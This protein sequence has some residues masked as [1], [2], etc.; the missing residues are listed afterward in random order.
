M[1]EAQ[2]CSASVSPQVPAEDVRLVSVVVPSHNRRHCL[3]YCLEALARQTYPNYEV[4][5]VDDGSDDGTADLLAEFGSQHPDLNLRW[6]VNESNIG[7][8]KSRNRGIQN[9]RGQLV[10]FLDSDCIAEP[11]W[12]ENLRRAFT[13]RQVAAVTGMVLNAPPSNIY[14][15]TYSGTNRVHGRRYPSRLT[16]CNMCVR[17]DLLVQ[18]PFDED[19]KYGC[20]E[21]GIYLRFRAIG[22]EQ[23]VVPDAVLRHEH[24][25]TRQTFFRQ[26][27]LGGAAAAWLV[28]KYR[29]LPRLDLLPF[30]LGY[31]TLPLGLVNAWLLAI[32]LLFLGVALVA[33]LYNELR[34]KNKT[35]GETLRSF[36]VLLTYYHIR[37]VSYLTQSVRLRLFC[38]NIERVRL[39][40][41]SAKRTRREKRTE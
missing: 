16:G 6:F 30:M 2:E 24:R 12:L 32:P 5:V 15:L 28:Y 20:D 4:I 18:Y 14:E 41:L 8:N 3:A 38:N 27:H 31:L 22:Y 25:F 26:A 40:E 29:L 19:L 39:R 33:L 21:E 35:I 1:T 37:L 9:C 17:R 23:K 34:R 11:D 7:A 10:A 13:S 36:P